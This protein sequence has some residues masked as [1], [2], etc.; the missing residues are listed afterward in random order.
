MNTH[1]TLLSSLTS[2]HIELVESL[3]F[4]DQT[5]LSIVLSNIYDSSMPLYLKISWGDGEIETFENNRCEIVNGKVVYF[6]CI[7]PL[8]NRTYTHTYYP[9]STSLYKNLSAQIF[10]E[11]PNNEKNWFILPIKIRTYDY[12][13]SIGEMTLINTNILPT[14]SNNKE[15]Q[16][17]IDKGDYVVEIRES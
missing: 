7:L 12:S 16:F 17:N 13:E 14:V 2:N 4:D 10:I 15:Y 11:Y 3:D 5:T 9:S 8:F 1:T 6:S